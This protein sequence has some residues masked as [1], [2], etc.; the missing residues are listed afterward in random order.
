VTTSKPAAQNAGTYRLR[1]HAVGVAGIVFF[2]ISAAAPLAATLGVAPIVFGTAGKGAPLAYA[3]AGV[4]LLLFSVGY[5]AMSRHVTSSAG[6]A[7]YIEKG[8]GRVPGFAAATTAVFSYNAMLIGIYG[9]FGFFTHA[10][11]DQYLGLDLPWQVWTFLAIAA[12]GM[13]G[14]LDI[15]LSARILGTLMIGEVALLLLFDIIV[16]ARGGAHGVSFDGF[17]PSNLLGS[18]AVGIAIL[19][20]AVCFVGFEATAIYGEEAKEPRRTIPRATYIAVVL[21]GV[22]YCLTMWAIGNAYGSNGVQHAAGAD[23]GNF[24]F[25]ANTKFVGRWATDALSILVVTSYFATLVAFHNTIARYM[26]SL[27]RGGALP[28]F[29]RVTH[30]RW[31]SPHAASLV[32]TGVSAVVVAAFA[33]GGADPFAQMFAWLTALGTIG[34]VALQAATTLAAIVFFRREQPGGLWT[35][36]VA[37]VLAAAGLITAIVLAVRNWGLLSGATS[38]FASQLPWLVVAAAAVGVVLAWF[39]RG[40][41]T[42][43][44]SGFQDRPPAEADAL[45]SGVVPP[46]PA[47]GPAPSAARE[48]TV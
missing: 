42:T 4:L 43:I 11:A 37:P 1:S 27:G 48:R 33:I 2:V 13:L 40:R 18:G 3:V 17:L 5:A 45:L 36:V 34:I 10:V 21:I 24:V 8:F 7:A 16:P 32:G 14:Y 20:A 30:R 25:N 22:F 29:L 46:I 12:V 41:V 19:F 26:F 9:A 35:T 31:Q 28:A 38:G 39:K 47:D 15:N 6:F 23:P 44:A